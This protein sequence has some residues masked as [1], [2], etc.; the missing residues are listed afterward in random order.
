MKL[1]LLVLYLFMGCW[2]WTNAQNP[3]CTYSISGKVLDADTEEPIP[4][5]VIRVDGREKY[6]TTDINGNFKIDGLC[7]DQNTLIISCI[8]YADATKEHD[9]DSDIH[10]YLTQEVTGLDEVTIQA[11]RAKEKGTATISQVTLG[12]AEITSNPTQSLAAVLDNIQG[13]TFASA[14]SNVQLPIIHGLSG[15]RILVLNNGLIHGFQ[16]WGTEHA[17][18]IDIS[19]ANSITV[20]KGAAGVRFGPEAL[21]GAI[22][23]EPNSLTLEKSF[24]TNIGTGYQTNGR[25]YNTNFQVENGSKNWSYYLN[26]N[27]TRIGD[28]EAPDYVL[29]NTGKEEVAFGFGV[30]RHF[31]NLDIKLNYSFIDQNLALLRASFVSSGPAIGRAINESEPVIIDPFSYEIRAPNQEVQHHLAKLEVNWWYGDDSQLTL[32]AGRQ[33]NKRDEFDVRRNI[34]RPIIDLDL[35][36]SD[37]QLQWK[38]PKWWDLDGLIGLQYFNQSNDNNPGTQ[39]T[40][41]IPNYD[42]NRYSAFAVEKLTKGKNTFEGGVRFDYENNDVRGRETNQDIFRDNYTFSNVTASLGYVRQFSNQ[43]SYRT[44]FGLA[45]RTPNAA[46]LFSFGQQGFQSIFG[47]LRFRFVDGTPSTSE[48]TLLD[49]SPVEPEVGYKFINEFQ[50][51]NGD[52]LHKLTVFSHYIQNFIYDRPLGV[53][54]TIRGPQPFYF[55]DQAD[56]LFLGFDYSWKRRWSKTVLGT[57]GLSYLWSRNIAENEPLINQPPISTNFELQWDQGKF[58]KFESSRFKIRPSYTFRQF[59]APRAVTPQELIDGVEVITPQS[60][61]FDFLPAPDGYFLLDVSWNLQ[62]KNFSASIAANNLLNTRYRN[63]LNEFRLF[64][65]EPGRNILVS[66]NYSFKS[67]NDD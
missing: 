67:K 25:G 50:T 39:T 7:S 59:Q 66:L 52:D 48:V 27:Y 53:F 44:N 19:A 49:D 47:L 63:Y 12:K 3:T 13:V 54:G 65:D 14:G 9:H 62:L 22:I 28:R 56:G 64:A 45:W 2:S 32:I 35:T 30:L 5:A 15:N 38:H 21:G 43:S 55:I 34:D 8:G 57:F 17:P 60:E 29:T 58:W 37:L 6:T 10:F 42:I 33:L 41:F 46:E 20:V 24:Q 31:K 61:I 26:G 23:V 18:E 16:N 11:A 36:T 4:S 40:A 1:K 51:S